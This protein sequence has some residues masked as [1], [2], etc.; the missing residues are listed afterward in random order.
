[1]FYDVNCPHPPNFNPKDE[2]QDKKPYPLDK[3]PFLTWKVDILDDVHRQRLR[4]LVAVDELVE[5]LVSVLEEL[6]IINNTYIF[7]TSDNG[8][9]M[10]EHRI[11]QEKTTNYEESLRVPFL[12]RGPG[13]PQGKVVDDIAL[14]IDLAPTW[15]ELAGVT[16]PDFVDGVS[17]VST[18]LGKE[19]KMEK[20]EVFVAE[21]YEPPYV[22]LFK[23][24]HGL[25]ILTQDGKHN[26]MY[27]VWDG[28][29]SECY[30][31]NQDRF[32]LANGCLDMPMSQIHSVTPLWDQ[33]S[34]CAGESCRKIR[35][36]APLCL[37]T[38]YG[39]IKGCVKTSLSSESTPL[40]SNT[41]CDI[42][43]LNC[44]EKHPWGE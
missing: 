14:N 43:P 20:R 22:G 30:D 7:Y 5:K 8:Y 29:R 36:L 25:R 40:S 4:T 16:P 23:E 1:M 6:D 9:A 11:A 27:T 42:T 21:N 17:L 33:L 34:T 41:K 3:S 37:K 44:D 28:N 32:E 2:I 24:Q 10:G 19:Q 12:V 35:S 39:P 38:P 18:L 13:I 31:I 26:L 15:A